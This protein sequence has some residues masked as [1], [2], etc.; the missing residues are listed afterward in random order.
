MKICP[1]EAELF[2]AGGRTDGQINRKTETTKLIVAFRNFANAPNK[3][4][5]ETL[6]HS[7]HIFDP[8]KRNGNYI[9]HLNQRLKLCLVSA[10]CIYGVCIILKISNCHFSTEN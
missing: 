3:H 7:L 6:S 8:L 2:H 5:T 9:C 1:V 4:I 10:E